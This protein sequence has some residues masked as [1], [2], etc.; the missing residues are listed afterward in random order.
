MPATPPEIAPEMPRIFTN[1][2]FFVISAMMKRKRGIKEVMSQ[3]FFL[4][5]L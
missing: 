2:F 3:A 1:E 4:F 5:I